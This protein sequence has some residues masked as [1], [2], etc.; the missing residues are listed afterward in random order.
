[1]N[2]LGDRQGQQVPL[3]TSRVSRSQWQQQPIIRPWTKYFAT[4]AVLLGFNQPQK[5]PTTPGQSTPSN[6]PT[7]SAA[8]TQSTPSNPPTPSAAQAQS[9]P[10]NSPTPSAPQSSPP[11]NATPSTAPNNAAPTSSGASLEET[12]PGYR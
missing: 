9:T 2:I 1:V 5:T 8:Q 12:D 11:S 4:S 6:P 7:P 3:L 10:G